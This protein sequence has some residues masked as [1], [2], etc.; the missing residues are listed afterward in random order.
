M[1]LRP[2]KPARG[3]EEREANEE[4][5]QLRGFGVAAAADGEVAAVAAADDDDEAILLAP[6][7]LLD[8]GASSNAVRSS[9]DRDDSKGVPD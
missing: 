9:E 5:L 8:A 2:E 7:H 4:E 6:P 3:V 1:C